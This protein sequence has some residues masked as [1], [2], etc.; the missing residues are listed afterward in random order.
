MSAIGTELDPL[1]GTRVRITDLETD[2]HVLL[3]SVLETGDTVETVRDNM[4]IGLPGEAG[5]V[6]ENAPGYAF[7]LSPRSWLLRMSEAGAE[8]ALDAA[9]TGF[10]DYSIHATP[11]SDAL[12]WF[13]ISGPGAGALLARGGFLT[14]SGDGF[15]TGHFK[16][17]LLADISVLLWR[18]SA[19]TWEVACERS[20]AKYFRD[21]LESSIAI[22]AEGATS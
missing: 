4:G 3:V 16:R 11:Y 1:D 14:L 19:E 13:E 9:R 22:A 8:T 15:R 18:R 17:T 7:W 20:R 10:P 2:A 12:T 6:N 5:T 21:W